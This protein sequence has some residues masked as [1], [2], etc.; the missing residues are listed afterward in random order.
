[1]TFKA[2]NTCLKSLSILKVFD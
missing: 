2:F 1:M